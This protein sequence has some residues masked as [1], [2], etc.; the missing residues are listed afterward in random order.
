MKNYIEVTLIA[1][2]DIKVYELWGK[3]YTQLHL[4][5]VEI[6]GVQGNVP[7]GISFPEYQYEP[8]RG[9]YLG[10]KLRIFAQ[11]EVILQQLDLTKWLLRLNDYIH[12]TGI[13]E[14]P[15]NGVIKYAQ[16]RR[17]HLKGS[18]EKLARRHASRHKINLDEVMQRYQGKVCGSDLPYVLLKSL[19][20][21]QPFRLF[22]E[23]REY[24]ESI[25]E[26]FGAYGLSSSS[27][28]P[29]F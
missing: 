7:I 11:D 23:K 2:A 24:N 4:A 28:V 5:L 25:Q 3:F 16:Y 27:T 22:I 15:N 9:G 6:Q 19:T 26:G 14:V 1:N 10:D 21:R 13:R 12:C 17:R 29:E 20:T 18:L 8:G